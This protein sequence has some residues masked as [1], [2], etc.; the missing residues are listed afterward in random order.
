M[1]SP[2]LSLLI[3]TLDPILKKDFFCKNQ[4]L[5]SKTDDFSR[6]HYEHFLVLSDFIK[7][8]ANAEDLYAAIRSNNY[9]SS[10][11]DYTTGNFILPYEIDFCHLV[12]NLEGKKSHKLLQNFANIFNVDSNNV[13]RHK[14]GFVCIFTDRNNSLMFFRCLNFIL[15]DGERANSYF[16]SIPRKKQMIQNSIPRSTSLISLKNNKKRFKH[17]KKDKN[18]QPLLKDSDFPSLN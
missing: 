3:D 7:L 15:L 5:I 11:F 12:V 18:K 16:K 8:R 10:I 1:R 4:Y 2:Y 13:Q 17:P 14:N 9:F 6:I